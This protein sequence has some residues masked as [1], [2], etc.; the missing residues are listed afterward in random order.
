MTYRFRNGTVVDLL[1]DRYPW[2]GFRITVRGAG[3]KIP[4][5]A[6]CYVLG[7][8]GRELARQQG[9]LSWPSTTTGNKRIFVNN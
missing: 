6:F 7:Y 9:L 4:S 8:R 5:L 2:S 3:Q 1:G